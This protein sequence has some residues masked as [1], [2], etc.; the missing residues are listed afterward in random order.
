MNHR[1]TEHTEVAQRRSRI[2]TFRAKPVKLCIFAPL[3]E[4]RSTAKF[5]A[6]DVQQQLHAG[7]ELKTTVRF[8]G[9]YLLINFAITR[10]NFLFLLIV[11]NDYR[12]SGRRY[13]A[14][15]TNTAVVAQVP[16]QR[17]VIRAHNRHPSLPTVLLPGDFLDLIDQIE[18]TSRRVSVNINIPGVVVVIVDE[19]QINALVYGNPDAND[20][21]HRNQP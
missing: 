12:L 8:V 18:S 15:I 17:P 14:V 13:P 10:V 6:P 3:R 21:D 2:E 16:R 11:G 1:G 20:Q 9:R 4:L 19:I 7:P 5:T